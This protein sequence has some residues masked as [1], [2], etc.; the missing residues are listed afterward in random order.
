M[1]GLTKHAAVCTVQLALVPH[2]HALQLFLQRCW[3]RARTLCAHPQL[4]SLSRERQPDNCAW[5]LQSSLEHR[6]VGEQ[7]IRHGRVWQQHE[8]T[9]H[10]A[11][12]CIV[13]Y[14]GCTMSRRRF[15]AEDQRASA[16]A[17]IALCMHTERTDTYQLAC[18]KCRTSHWCCAA[19]NRIVP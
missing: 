11:Y 7:M 8:R 6:A 17:V 19:V 10:A 16:T 5:L 14:K 4:D 9:I 1:P 15:Q 18:L 3:P 2:Q 12:G 13:T